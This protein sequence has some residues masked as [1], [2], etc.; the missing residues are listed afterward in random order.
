[1]CL[2]QRLLDAIEM[3]AARTCICSN[4]NV[5]NTEILMNQ[6]QAAMFFAMLADEAS[7]PTHP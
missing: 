7:F 2:F 3:K 5:N 4:F 1:M 6:A